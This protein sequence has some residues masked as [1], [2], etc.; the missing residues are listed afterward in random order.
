MLLS[1]GT[2][3]GGPK[4]RLILHDDVLCFDH[5]AAGQKTILVSRLHIVSMVIIPSVK[6]EAEF[7]H[8]KMVFPFFCSESVEKKTPTSIVVRA[9]HLL[10]NRTST[11]DSCLF[12][13]EARA[14]DLKPIK[15]N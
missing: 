1:S 14:S 15:I 8:E 9:F 6:T 3:D 11:D 13:L 7:F 10:V 5:H 12:H 2:C 4:K